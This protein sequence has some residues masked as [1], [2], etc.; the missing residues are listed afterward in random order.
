MEKKWKA[1]YL[2]GLYHEYMLKKRQENRGCEM[3]KNIKYRYRNNISQKD[4][5]DS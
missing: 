2:S 1:L 5:H 3:G 4:K